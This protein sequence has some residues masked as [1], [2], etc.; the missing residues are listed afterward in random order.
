MYDKTIQ[1]KAKTAHVI[2]EKHRRANSRIPA[3]IIF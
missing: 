2:I 3:D 1:L